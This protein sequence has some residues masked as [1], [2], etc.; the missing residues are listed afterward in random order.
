MLE[1]L[2]NPYVFGAFTL[3]FV[4]YGSLAGPKLP[5]FVKRVFQNPVFQLVLFALIAYRGNH[6]PFS[7]VMISVGFLLIMTSIQRDWFAS[8]TGLVRSGAFAAISRGEEVFDF[9]EDSAVGLIRLPGKAAR[10]TYDVAT[11]AA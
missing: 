1:I 10:F 6:D 7:A 5:E 11:S 3:V 4:L 2:D 9:A 8:A